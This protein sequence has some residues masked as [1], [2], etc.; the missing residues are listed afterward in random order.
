MF[1]TALGRSLIWKG[2]AMPY[3]FAV[4]FLFAA[5]W[6]VLVFGLTSKLPFPL[7]GIGVLIVG[8]IEMLFCWIFDL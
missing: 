5:P 2:D 7:I 3:P 8:I 6:I 1:E 4:A